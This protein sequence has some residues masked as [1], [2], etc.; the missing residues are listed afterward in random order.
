MGSGRSDWFGGV[1]ARE[2]FTFFVHVEA[3]GISMPFLP[4]VLLA[5]DLESPI[6]IISIETET[7]SQRTLKK[8]VRVRD[9]LDR[10]TAILWPIDLIA[11]L[12][13]RWTSS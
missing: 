7:K 5:E 2:D 1:D 4:W 12:R 10:M 6:V 9:L 3:F 8:I 13:A 11:L